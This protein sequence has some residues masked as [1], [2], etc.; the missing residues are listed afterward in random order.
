MI[1]LSTFISFRSFLMLSVIWH[2]YESQAKSCLLNEKAAKTHFTQMVISS[3]LILVLP[4]VLTTQRDLNS[5]SSDSDS[6]LAARKTINCFNLV[7][8]ALAGKHKLPYIFHTQLS[9][10]HVDCSVRYHVIL[11]GCFVRRCYT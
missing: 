4:E 11:D 5:S 10:L 3:L 2:L 9:S 6:L 7:P 8:S 1:T